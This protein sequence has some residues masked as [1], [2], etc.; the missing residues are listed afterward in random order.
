MPIELDVRKTIARLFVGTG[1]YLTAELNY[2]HPEWYSQIY[3]MSK[4]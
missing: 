1:V 4:F 3:S 2:I